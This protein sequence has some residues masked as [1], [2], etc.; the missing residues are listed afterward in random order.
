[1]GE[2]N[3]VWYIFTIADSGDLEFS[4][5]P[6]E[7]WDDYDFALFNL[8]GHSCKE[9][10]NEDIEVRCNFAARPTVTGLQSGH[11]NVFE[12]ASGIPSCS[13]LSVKSGETYVLMISNFSTTNFGYRL[14]LS[15]GSATVADNSPPEIILA[16]LGKD[17]MSVTVHFS[18]PVACNSI[19]PAGTNFSISGPIPLKITGASGADC[20][21]GSF[22]QQVK[23]YLASPV[24]VPGRYP[25]LIK[26]VSGKYTLMNLCGSIPLPNIYP[27]IIKSYSEIHGFEVR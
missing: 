6:N 2:Y 5:T 8:T 16:E 11:E 1:M 7:S 10:Y 17:S 13:P 14:N 26:P 18:N 21:P 24:N 15:L 22:T 27:L 9:I 12:S 19:D 4:I 3:S 25:I 23:I 20:S